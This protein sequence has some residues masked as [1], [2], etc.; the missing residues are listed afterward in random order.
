MFAVWRPAEGHAPPTP[1][2][3]PPLRVK[4]NLL[5]DSAGT[6]FQLRGVSLPG[7]EAISP[8]AADVANVNAMTGFTFRVMRQRWNMNAVRLPVSAAVWKRDGPGYL[9][10]VASVVALANGESLIV[11]L[12]AQQDGSL[13]D[14][15]LLDFWKACATRFANTPG[16]IL[17]LCNEPSTRDIAGSGAAA[18]RPADWQVWRNGGALASGAAAVGMQD[19]VNAIRAAGAQ[20]I[21]AA[22]GFQN[23]A[24]FQGFSAQFYL[25]DANVMY[26]WHPYFDVALTDEERIAS[27]GFLAG[28]FPLYAG[29]WGMP[30]GHATAACTAIPRDVSQAGDLLQAAMAYFDFR[31]VSWTVTDFTPGSLIQ[32]FTD[33]PATILGHWTCDTTSDPGSG[34]GQFV[35]LWMTGDAAGFGSLAVDE[36]A[37]VAGGIPAPVAPGE[38]ISLYGE[39]IGP[40]NAVA[41]PLD[42]S[43]R[44][45]TTLAETQ[46]LFDGRPAPLLFTWAFQVNVQVPY[47]VAGRKTTTVQLVYRGVPSNTVDLAVV[48]TAPGLLTL[49]GTSQA[50]AL[51]QDGSVND[52]TNP[53]ARGS[54]ISFFAVGAGVMKGG[55]PTGVAA[56]NPLGV[57][58]LPVVL[59]MANVAAEVLYA[60]EAP[61]LVGCLQVNARIPADFPDGDRGSVVLSVG[62]AE[63]RV[64]VTF[65]VR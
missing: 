45:A 15:A 31:N 58:S 25:A 17:A 60:G 12:G 36:I 44:V 26:E 24:G 32:T 14:A 39:G 51:N 55:A 13:P 65:W 3:V 22:A 23:R 27:F 61:G 20:Q 47:E 7:L 40:A 52:I 41:G 42:A 56:G 11:V 9:D 16:L 53:A 6:V 29:A 37:S 21:I 34:I 46:V 18:N 5:V 1:I 48:D 49:L 43:G 59:K 54:V 30:F 19:L 38:I 4:A 33:Y 8:T 50:A 10:R 28:T 62:G 35:L 63:S 57:P 64:G 2:P